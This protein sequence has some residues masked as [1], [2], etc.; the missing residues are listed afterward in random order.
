MN[1]IAPEYQ[2]YDDVG[3][4]R[5]YLKIVRDP[6]K[7]AYDMLPSGETI[8]EFANR[9]AVE[10]YA[11]KIESKRERARESRRKKRKAGKLYSRPKKRLRHC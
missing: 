10:R 7:T 11:R 5:E 2:S 6:S 3:R 9:H 1:D 8:G 4:L